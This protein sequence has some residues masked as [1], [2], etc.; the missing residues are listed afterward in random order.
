MK[1]KPYPKYKDSGIEWL[2]KVPAGWDVVR[3]KHLGGGSGAKIQM[4][5]F[6]SMLTTLASEPTEFRLF[7]QENTISGDFRTGERCLT[8]EQ[9]RSLIKYALKPGDIVLTRKGSLGKARL[10]PDDIRPGIADSDTIRIRLTRDALTNEFAVRL[11]HEAPYLQVQIEI[12]SRGA[13][14]GGLNTT[15]IGDLWLAVP[16]YDEEIHIDRFLDKETDRIDTL[17]AKQERLIGLLK[18]KRQAV[19]SHAAA[20]GLNPAAPMKHSGIDWLGEI[21]EHWYIRR[22]KHVAPFI[23]VGI[24]V[25]PSDYVADEGLPFI[26]GGDLQE[27]R[28]DFDTARRISPEA[29]ERNAKTRLTPGDLLTVRVGAPG[30]TAVVPNECD[31]GNCASVMLM[32]RGSFDSQWLC[33]AMNSRMVRFQVKVVQ[34]GQLRSSS[35]SVT[36]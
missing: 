6:G 31:R 13:I 1:W 19:I 8:E 29:S 22:L 21:P 25:N 15:T 34:Y 3:L 9:Y 24:V 20:K 12:S 7:G 32:R 2:G 33:Y 23:T 27:G 35:I 18:E 17:I 11:L 4:G 5:P 30:V 16:S 26:Y 36:P 10:V 14:L 28:I